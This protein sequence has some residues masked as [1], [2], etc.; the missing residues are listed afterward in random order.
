MTNN[1]K[2]N[3]MINASSDPRRMI[4]ALLALAPILREARIQKR[5]QE[6]AVVQPGSEYL[7]PMPTRKELV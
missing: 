5:E 3:Q 2:F 1:E 7:C 6:A 4:A